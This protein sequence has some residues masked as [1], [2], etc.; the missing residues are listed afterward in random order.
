M[1]A[2]QEISPWDKEQAEAFDYPI[3]HNL[4]KIDV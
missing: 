3:E 2:K 1:A 4:I